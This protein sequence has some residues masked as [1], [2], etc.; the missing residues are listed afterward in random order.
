MAKNHGYLIPHVG[1]IYCR[2]PACTN[3]FQTQ[4]LNTNNLKKHIRKAHVDKFDLLEKEGGGRP[5]AK[6]EDDVIVFYKAVLEAYDARQEDGVGKPEIP[7]RRDGKINQSAVKKYVREQG[8]SVP[9][10]ACKEADKAKDCCREANLDVC[11]HF[12]LFE[13]YEDE[14]EAESNEVF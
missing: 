12:E 7:C 8:Y 13:P 2:A 6:E 1:E 10:D 14:E 11:D 9:C 5:T 4:F 3:S